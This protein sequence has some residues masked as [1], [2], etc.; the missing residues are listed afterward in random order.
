MEL[1]DYHSKMENQTLILEI[2]L[3]LSCD[4]S[5]HLEL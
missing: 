1:D 2:Y 3:A 4:N 5:I